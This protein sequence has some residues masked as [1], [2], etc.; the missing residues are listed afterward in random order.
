MFEKKI[1]VKNDVTVL[2][3]TV[4]AIRPDNGLLLAQ[5]FFSAKA[6]HVEVEASK[7]MPVE[8]EGLGLIIQVADKKKGQEGV[9]KVDI[10]EMVLDLAMDFC[11]Q[12]SDQSASQPKKQGEPLS[13]KD[14][15][16]MAK[17]QMSEGKK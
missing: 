10:A 11:E 1:T 2:T 7:E 16:A 5:G 9:F 14:M 8:G 12:V 17:K 15:A 3:T 6:D 13:D 4:E